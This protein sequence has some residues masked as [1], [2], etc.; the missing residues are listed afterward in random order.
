LPLFELVRS[1]ASDDAKALGLTASMITLSIPNSG[2]QSGNAPPSSSAAPLVGDDPKEGSGL[3][4]GTAAGSGLTVGGLAGIVV[5]GVCAVVVASA[6][7]A[8]KITNRNA[9]LRART[10]Q[11]PVADPNQ[12][13]TGRNTG[14]TAIADTSRP[15]TAQHAA[16]SSTPNITTTT[17]GEIA[18]AAVSKPDSVHE[19][20]IV[21]EAGAA[22]V[23]T[24]DLR[25]DQVAADD[26][27]AHDLEISPNAQ[28]VEI[29]SPSG[30]RMRSPNGI[31]SPRGTARVQAERGAPTVNP[32]WGMRRD[33]S[34]VSFVTSET[35]SGK[36]TP[37][38]GSPIT[39]LTPT[40]A[41]S[42]AQRRLRNAGSA[43]VSP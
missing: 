11:T 1:A 43:A 4:G 26:T 14:S 39:S 3:F 13:V 23:S 28:A 37:K 2:V 29:G 41:A 36:L 18:L 15:A 33:N 19:E 38:L 7:M 25:I 17:A 40:N 42:P 5:A 31:R 12:I 30:L 27:A 35:G 21:E 9:M 24:A 16:V 34:A 8:V 10:A 6:F 20:Q 22:T 32:S